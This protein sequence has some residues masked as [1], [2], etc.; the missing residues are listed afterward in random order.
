MKK[1]KVALTFLLLFF[2]ECFSQQS[3]NNGITQTAIK[4]GIGTR[5]AIAIVVS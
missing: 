5:S 1:I 3:G 4:N 2:L